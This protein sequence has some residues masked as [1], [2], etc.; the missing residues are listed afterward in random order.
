MCKCVCAC[1][2]FLK[3]SGQ[4]AIKIRGD[5]QLKLVDEIKC[6]ACV[7]LSMCL[8]LSACMHVC[9]LC[10]S[11]YVSMSAGYVSVQPMHVCVYVCMCA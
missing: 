8:C 4:L 11:V 10:L 7:S 3:R 9:C 6:A 5:E 1:V 2:R